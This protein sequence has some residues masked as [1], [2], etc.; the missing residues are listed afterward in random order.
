M[1]MKEKLHEGKNQNLSKA[2]VRFEL[3][4]FFVC[5][6]VFQVGILQQFLGLISP[7]KILSRDLSRGKEVKNMHK[8]VYK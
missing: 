4:F 1:L 7:A 5:L 8:I 3:F 2:L 6:F